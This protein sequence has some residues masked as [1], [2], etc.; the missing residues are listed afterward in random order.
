MLVNAAC[1]LVLGDWAVEDVVAAP[2]QD[3]VEVQVM[4]GGVIVR[5]IV[6]QGAGPVSH[7]ELAAIASHHPITV[8][9]MN[10]HMP[11]EMLWEGIDEEAG[12]EQLWL[13]CCRYWR[14][15]LIRI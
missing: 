2:L 3:I 7:L 5:V 1:V 10:H 15:T 9:V 14:M 11:M 4:V 13:K 6:P 12:A 8:G